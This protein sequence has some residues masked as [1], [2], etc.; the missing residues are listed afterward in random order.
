[1]TPVHIEIKNMQEKQHAI[2]TEALKLVPFEGWT[3]QT[4]LDATKNVGLDPNYAEIAFPN[5]VRELVDFFLRDLDS[6]MLEKLEK[7][8]LR[9]LKIREKIALAIKTRIELIADNKLA[10]R[11][12]L[13]F[14][15]QP[16]NVIYSAPALWKTVDT[17]WYAAGDNSSDFNYYTKR[18]TLAGVYTSTLLYWLKDKSSGHYET[19]Q[20]L[21]RRIENVMSFN[22]IKEKIYGMARKG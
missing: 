1:M 16:Q 18:A 3:R 12:T 10:I 20:F 11:K 15:A 6:K 5:G 17:I 4:L 21:S 2:L 13:A 9:T 19:W 8:D 14:Y 22:K 7:S